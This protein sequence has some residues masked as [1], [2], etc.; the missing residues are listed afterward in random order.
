LHQPEGQDQ[1]R[2]DAIELKPALGGNFLARLVVVGALA[3]AAVAAGLIIGQASTGS[4]D[5]GGASA[6]PSDTP[7]NWSVIRK[8]SPLPVKRKRSPRHPEAPSQSGSAGNQSTPEQGS[9]STLTPAPIAPQAPGGESNEA[10][11]PDPDPAPE[12]GGKSGTWS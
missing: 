8:P 4:S 7:V 6:V 9:G 1:V 3:V 11:P 2:P 10:P 5:E 12:R